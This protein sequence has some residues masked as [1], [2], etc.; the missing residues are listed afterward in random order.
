MHW[1]EE[2]GFLPWWS[3]VEE[4]ASDPNRHFPGLIASRIDWLRDRYLESQGKA[5]R[6]LVIKPK[7]SPPTVRDVYEKLWR[8][9]HALSWFLVYRMLTGSEGSSSDDAIGLAAGNAM[10]QELGIAPRY[11]MELRITVGAEGQG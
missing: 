6:P 3:H 11:T 1:M 2:Y 9:T 5:S 10:S 7:E 8:E 4:Y